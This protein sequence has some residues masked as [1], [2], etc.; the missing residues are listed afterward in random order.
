[1]DIATNVTE[2]VGNTP[3][4]WLS[5]FSENLAAKLESC[6]PMSSIKDRVAIAMLE[7]ADRRG[8]LTGDSIVVEA[9]SGNTGIGLGMACAATG[10]RLTVTMPESASCKRV[11][12]LESV[13]F[14]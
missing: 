10:R 7:E 4:V 12:I 8:L 6:N 13:D 3:L 1:M 14:S 2:L 9:T 11:R 5:S